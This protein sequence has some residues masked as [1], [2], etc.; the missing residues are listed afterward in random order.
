MTT[1]YFLF[2]QFE[3]SP[4]HLGGPA[5]TVSITSLTNIS[6]I[7]LWARKSSCWMRSLS[8]SNALKYKMN[9]NLLLTVDNVNEHDQRIV[10]LIDVPEKVSIQPH[11]SMILDKIF[12]KKS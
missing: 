7:F 4:V 3:D 8:L 10:L 5:V 1:L 11:L 9:I 6:L 12:R 2:S